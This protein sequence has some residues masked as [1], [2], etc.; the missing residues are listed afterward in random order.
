M[1]LSLNWVWGI[2]HVAYTSTPTKD[3]SH[4]QARWKEKREMERW[5]VI[6]KIFIILKRIYLSLKKMKCSSLSFFPMLCLTFLSSKTSTFLLK[7]VTIVCPHSQYRDL[8][9]SISMAWILTPKPW[10]LISKSHFLVFWSP[11]AWIS[12]PNVGVPNFNPQCHPLKSY[13]NP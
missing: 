13:I 5:P 9:L 1:I 6:N 11:M 2:T 7:F 8:Q 3:N 12:L 10:V 4:I